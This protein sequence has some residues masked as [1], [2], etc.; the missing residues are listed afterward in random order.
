MPSPYSL[1]RGRRPS[2]LLA[3]LRALPLW[4]L[5][6]G[7]LTAAGCGQEVSEPRGPSGGPAAASPPGERPPIVIDGAFEDWDDLAPAHRDP[8]GDGD[9]GGMDLGDLWL[10]DDGR[11]LYLR[12]QLGEAEFMLQEEN[13]LMLYLDT[14]GDA[15]TGEAVGGLGADVTWCFGDKRG[16]AF[17]DAGPVK[18][19]HGGLGL[20]LA[21]SVSS[22]EF[23]VAIDR[24]ARPAG[25]ELFPSGTFRLA[26]AEAGGDRQP[27]SGAVSHRF[28]PAPAPP[29]RPAGLPAKG[30]GQLRLAT[31]N[32]EYDQLF[33]PERQD[34]FGRI[35]GAVG[36]DVLGLQE[37]YEHSAEE[38]LAV[39][40]SLLPGS[41]HAAKVGVDLVAVSRYPILR[42]ECI[43]YCD[44]IGSTGVFLLDTRPLW[45]RQ[46]LLVL[47]HPPCCTGGD[48]P[49]DAGRQHVLDA[50]MAYLRDATSAAG[51]RRRPGA[52]LERGTPILIAGDMNLVGDSQQLRTLVEGE[53]VDAAS[54]GP[55]PARDWDGTALADLMPRHLDLPMTFTW[56]RE[57]RF[58]PGRL[59]FIVYSDSVLRAERGFVLYTPAMTDAALEAHG[60]ERADTTRASDH[61]PVVGDF[62]LRT[63]NH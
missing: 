27:D 6:L 33:D 14:D 8:R 17:A 51:E 53:I 1:D 32:V 26:L 24:R 22:A 52:G 47:A 56:T 30:E 9:D 36:A 61:L 60:L 10:A 62:S 3:G 11:F 31:Y 13:R 19:E 38:T 16:T 45:G 63:G 12:F 54:F 44:E 28:A 48:P 23:E 18:I 49:A 4:A 15:E 50:T 20:V 55:T 40:G 25:E 41:W 59:D 5:S 37:I 39:I 42:T 21:P 2:S 57:G 34:A 7:A 58:S 46:T 35:L 29:P 43:V